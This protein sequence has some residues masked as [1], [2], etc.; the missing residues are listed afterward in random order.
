MFEKCIISKFHPLQ[1]SVL[2]RFNSG[3]NKLNRQ[4]LNLVWLCTWYFT[5]HWVS[6]LLQSR[7]K[8]SLKCHSGKKAVHDLRF[9]TKRQHTYQAWV[10]QC[11][12]TARGEKG[13]IIQPLATC[14]YSMA[15]GSTLQP[16]NTAK[17][18]VHTPLSA[19]V[20]VPS[21]LLCGVWNTE[22]RRTWG[23]LAHV[24]NRTRNAH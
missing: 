14:R 2:R 22:S 6:K 5:I 21:P 7:L 3:F 13:N 18:A 12:F 8:G 16:A 17:T 10:V 4:L 24:L 20:E 11:L 15:S 19:A 23:L 1:I 9:A